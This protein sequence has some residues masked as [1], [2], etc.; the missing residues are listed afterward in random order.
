MKV[1]KDGVVYHVVIEIKDDGDVSEE[2]KAK[3]KY[4]IQHF[5]E[6]NKR[7]EAQGINERYIFHFLSP[8]GYDVFFNHLRDGSVLAG[9]DRIKCQLEMLLEEN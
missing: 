5:D 9:Q 1:E 4:A 2:N 3:N 8:N 7:M 6:L